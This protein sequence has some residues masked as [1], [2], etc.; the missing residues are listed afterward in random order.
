[1]SIRH[2]LLGEEDGILSAEDEVLFGTSVRKRFD[3]STLL[4]IAALLA[5]SMLAG[6]S[7]GIP[8]ALLSDRCHL[9]DRPHTV[10]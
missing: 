5:I 3:R 2:A 6:F 1:M 7:G 10:S 4:F 9:P 8:I